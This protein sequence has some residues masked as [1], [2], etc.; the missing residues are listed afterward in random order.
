M[1]TIF[2]EILQLVVMLSRNYPCPRTLYIT[3]QPQPYTVNTIELKKYAMPKGKGHFH[4]L[5]ELFCYFLFLFEG[6]FLMYVN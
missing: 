5:T 4:S 3:V 2:M 6:L 1:V